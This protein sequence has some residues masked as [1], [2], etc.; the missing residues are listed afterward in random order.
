MM[1]ETIEPVSIKKE[2]RLLE[3]KACSN[4]LGFV[5]FG[6]RQSRAAIGASS[7]RS[8]KIQLDENKRICNL[9]LRIDKQLA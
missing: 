1:T 6:L 7:F 3:S 2:M 8:L 5:K 4:L 9:G